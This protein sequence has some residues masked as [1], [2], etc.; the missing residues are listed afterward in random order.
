MKIFMSILA[1]LV[2]LNAHA[3]DQ[4]AGSSYLL[5]NLKPLNISYFSNATN[6][7]HH[8]RFQNEQGSH[9]LIFTGTEPGKALSSLLHAVSGWNSACTIEIDC[10]ARAFCTGDCKNMYYEMANDSLDISS[11]AQKCTLRSYTCGSSQP[12]ASLAPNSPSAGNR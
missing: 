7:R 2:T 11:A 4:V 5:K 12:T 10:A 9:S 3:N 8:L 1:F 6:N